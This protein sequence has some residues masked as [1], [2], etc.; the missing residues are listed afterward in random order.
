MGDLPIA[1]SNIKINKTKIN[2]M[3]KQFKAKL[4]E[5]ITNN[6]NGFTIDFNL[7]P[8]RV[9]NGY[10]IAISNNTEKDINKAIDNILVLKEKYNHFKKMFIGGWVDIKTNTYF[11]D[12]TIYMK[13]K[14]D[15]III[16]QLFNQKAIFDFKNL[17]SIYL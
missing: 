14:Q 2:K 3:T 17:N 6:Q 10:A 8:L 11:L 1:I 16:G 5:Y 7:K 15:S 4:K 9:K 12:L 13:N